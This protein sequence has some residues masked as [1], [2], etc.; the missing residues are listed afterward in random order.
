MGELSARYG[1][2]WHYNGWSVARVHYRITN[3]STSETSA[4]KSNVSDLVHL[5]SKAYSDIKSSFPVTGRSKSKQAHADEEVKWVCN[6]TNRGAL[7]LR[8]H[9]YIYPVTGIFDNWYNV[10]SF[11]VNAT[12]IACGDIS[13]HV[14]MFA[15]KNIRDAYYRFATFATIFTR[16][17]LY[18]Y[19]RRSERRCYL[20]Y[21]LEAG[22]AG[23]STNESPSGSFSTCMHKLSPGNY[24][25]LI[26]PHFP[27]HFPLQIHHL[28]NHRRPKTSFSTSSTED[29]FTMAEI[30][31]NFTRIAIK[32]AEKLV[33]DELHGR[34]HHN[35]M[36]SSELGHYDK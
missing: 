33:L 25:D 15:R 6:T 5:F 17:N 9:A 34:C 23:S 32:I 30:S 7:C 31:Q 21:L 36:C 28:R 14:L 24:P 20:W 4:S 22:G 18:L 12:S 13:L 16:E 29:L 10:I 3:F 8:S 27:R 1:Q 11:C 2:N 26:H 19:G 35:K